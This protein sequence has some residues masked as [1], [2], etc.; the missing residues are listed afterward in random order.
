MYNQHFRFDATPFVLTPQLRFLYRSPSF[1]TAMD[2][3]AAGLNEDDA[4]ILVTGAI[5]TGKTLLLQSVYDDL[6]A[7][8]EVALVSNTLV[9][10]AGLL[11]L[12]LREL[13]VAIPS[14]LG[15]T[16]LLD[17][18]RTYAGRTDRR[19]KVVV[20]IDEAHNLSDDT[21]RDVAALPQL[22]ETGGRVVQ[23]VL[24]GRPDLE[25]RLQRAGTRRH[26]VPD[27]HVRV[28]P[29]SEQEVTDYI[30]H[31]LA[32]VGNDR[33]L[34]HRGALKRI[35][36]LS[37]GIPR[38]VNTLASNALMSAFLEDRRAVTDVHIKD[39]SRN[40][41]YFMPFDRARLPGNV[42]SLPTP[43]S[44]PAFKTPPAIHLAA[45]AAISDPQ[46]LPPPEPPA[47]PP[48]EPVETHDDLAFV[49]PV[50]ANISEAPALPALV[51]DEI[52]D[53][54]PGPR[55]DL[56]DGIADSADILGALV[57]MDDGHVLAARLGEGLDE[58]LLAASL[59]PLIQTCRQAATGATLADPEEIILKT[60]RGFLVISPV[61]ATR[62]LIIRTGAEAKLGLIQM[63][64]GGWLRDLAD[65]I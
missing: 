58:G 31:R 46:P 13:G 45:P 52:D 35:Y 65:R 27:R 16:G 2:S 9:R 19:A 39:P 43:E 29:L 23:L 36:D 5:G 15:T 8:C 17:V 28:F 6:A 33:P 34:F 60:G 44:R 42:A 38:V 7:T 48:P 25:A 4:V 47:L 56:L 1:V 51:E 37:S 32:V 59:P 24:A 22:A 64:L 57:M 55:H 50:A 40:A 49:L 20:V 21:L 3:L 41:V 53:A 26:P 14:D 63:E 62:W 12:V 61:D 11:K 54:P 10:T 30:G 18:F